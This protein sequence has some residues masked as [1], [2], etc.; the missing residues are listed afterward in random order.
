M[1][2]QCLILFC[3]IGITSPVFSEPVKLSLTPQNK[4]STCYDDIEVGDYIE[5]KTTKDVYK[6]GK[7]YITKD[8]PIYGLVDFVSDNGWGFDSAQIDFKKFKT[9]TVTEKPILIEAPLAINGFTILKDKSNRIA[10]FFNYCGVIFRGKE[11][12][13]IP[14]KDKIEFDIQFE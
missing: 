9:K 11:V 7:L 2:K 3:L 6:N 12:E 4:I 13:I 14:S 1:L 10:Q 5:F 8:T